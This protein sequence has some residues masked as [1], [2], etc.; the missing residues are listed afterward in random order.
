VRDAAA[1]QGAELYTT[2]AVEAE[3]FKDKLNLYL[4][5]KA[6]ACVLCSCACV[7]WVC[8]PCQLP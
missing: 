5:R 2:G 8:S 7:S 6:C 4:I 1:E 3:G